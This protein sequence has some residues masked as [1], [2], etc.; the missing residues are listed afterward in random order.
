MSASL[1]TL[2]TPLVATAMALAALSLGAQSAEAQ[3]RVIPQVGMYAPATELPDVGDAVEFGRREASLAYGAALEFGPVR[4]AVLHGS[5]G[6]VPVSGVDCVDCSARSTVTAATAALVVRPLP[7]M[8]L[9]QPFVLLGAGVKRYDFTR[10][11]LESE[12]AEAV[13][14]DA[15]DATGHFGLGF[16]FDLG[17]LSALV[18]LQ[19]LVSNFDAE[20]VDSGFQH[21][22]FLTVGLAL[23]W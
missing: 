10:E 16:E 2:R 21:D 12:G 18:E 3:F 14:S 15:N 22:M 7:Q 6:D 17:G 20:G 19:D 1:P 8:G 9:F 13:L 4:L 23:G 5:D 11:N